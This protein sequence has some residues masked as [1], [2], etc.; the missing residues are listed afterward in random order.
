M[1]ANR[2]DSSHKPKQFT[3]IANAPE[4]FGALRSLSAAK[5]LTALTRSEKS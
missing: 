2:Q 4:R 1:K 5:I 3:G